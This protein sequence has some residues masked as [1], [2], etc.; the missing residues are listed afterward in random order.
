MTVQRRNSLPPSIVGHSSGDGSVSPDRDPFVDSP[1]GLPAPQPS[2]ARSSAD[3]DWDPA[4][5]SHLQQVEANYRAAQRAAY[6]EARD[7]T[8]STSGSGY[9]IG[10]EQ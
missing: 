5:A 10:G 2:P 9:A 3:S 8:Q 4:T 7:I 6:G 1:T